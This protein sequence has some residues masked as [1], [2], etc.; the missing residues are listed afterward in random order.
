MSVVISGLEKRYDGNK[1]I[2]DLS[3]TFVSGVSS[4]ILGASGCGK[5]TALRCIAGLEVPSAGRITIKGED[6]FWLEKGIYVAPEKRNVAMVFQSYAIWPHMTVFENVCLP[7]KAH[8]IGRR[9]AKE[10][11]E[12]ALSLVGLKDMASR[13]ATKLSGGQQQRVALARSIVRPSKV[14]LLDEPLSNLDAK[15]RINMRREL[16][17]LQR[18]LKT[19]MIFVTHDQ[20]EAMSLADEIFLMDK[21]R[22]IA[23]G[24]PDELYQRPKNRFVAEFFGKANFIPI[25]LQA[26]DGGTL[27]IQTSSGLKITR[28][29]GIEG[30]SE[31]QHA[32]CVIRPEAWRIGKASDLSIP[33]RVSSMLLLGDRKEILV[34][35]VFGEQNVI[36]F[37]YENICPGETVNLSVEPAC[38]HLIPSDSQ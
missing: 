8:G 18:Q 32:V 34:E 24:S 6:V 2:D 16:K 11:A 10:M 9:E 5:T 20:E 3:A 27:N 35:T 12:N 23:K 33:G 7:L 1:V 28:V 31:G 29:R 22:I 37:S 30:F 36:I 19:T 14:L 25:T 21:G 15:L 13:G 38:I 26:S 4:I 17:E